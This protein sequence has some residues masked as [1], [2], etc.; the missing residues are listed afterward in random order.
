MLSLHVSTD[1]PDCDINSSF[2]SFLYR[3]TCPTQPLSITL[4][5]LASF[6]FSDISTFVG[7]SMPNPS[8]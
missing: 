4:L 1:E 2:T 3:D 6:F 8:F 5:L 7:Y